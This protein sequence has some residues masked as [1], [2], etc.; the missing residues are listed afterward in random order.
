MMAV[1]VKNL[2]KFLKNFA[3][4]AGRLMSKVGTKL[5]V[6]N[7]Q[8]MLKIGT[9]ATQGVG[10]ANVVQ[11]SVSKI[12]LAQK[13]VDV[14]TSQNALAELW[15]LREKQDQLSDSMQESLAALQK[16]IARLNDILAKV[17]ADNTLAGQHILQN[18]SALLG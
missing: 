8:N 3:G 15:E 17:I 4:K 5:T 7:H 12:N 16:Y 13:N 14:A 10:T 2:P 18:K 11:S 9:L 6:E 1:L